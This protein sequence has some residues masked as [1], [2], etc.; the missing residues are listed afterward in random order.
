ML[1]A[2]EGAAVGGFIVREGEA[3]VGNTTDHHRYHQARSLALQVPKP[4]RQLLLICCGWMDGWMDGCM[5]MW[6]EGK[7]PVN[8]PL[9]ETVASIQSQVAKIEDDMKLRVAEY[10]NVKSHLGAINRKQTGSCRPL[11]M[12]RVGAWS[13][14]TRRYCQRRR[15]RSWPTTNG[16]WDNGDTVQRQH[17]HHRQP[18]VPAGQE[19]AGTLEAPK[20][21]HGVRVRAGR[22][23]ER[24]R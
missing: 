6:D 14:R 18:C 17:R 13:W 19:V 15:C 11:P 8:A 16:S 4:A 20:P 21:L 10:G 24:H 23:R 9:K 5:F 12:V 2:A 7:Y 1:P 22:R 3:D